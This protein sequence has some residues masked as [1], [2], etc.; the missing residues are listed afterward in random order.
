[1]NKENIEKLI[2]AIEFDGK[3]K[4]NMATFVGEVDR[5]S[6]TENDY[7]YNQLVNVIFEMEDFTST[8]LFN[9]DSVGCIAGFATAVANDWKNPFLNLSGKEGKEHTSYYFEKEANRFLGLTKN[10][11]KSLYYGGDY[12][13]WKYLLWTKDPRFS[14]LKLE[15][16]V[17]FE[18]GYEYS[19]SQY[20]IDYTTITPENAITLL[21]MLIDEEIVLDH[22]FGNGPIFTADLAEIDTG[23]ESI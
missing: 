22:G 19:D 21:K 5:E 2:K 4:F 7:V 1:M 15:N 11:G 23:E 14:N 10:E 17:W 16:D 6:L 12:S 9:C 13:V 8:D 3:H 18:Y 20:D